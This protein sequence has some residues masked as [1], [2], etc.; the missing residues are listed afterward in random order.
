ML[1]GRNCLPTSKDEQVAAAKKAAAAPLVTSLGLRSKEIG[2]QELK[3]GDKEGKTALPNAK[4]TPKPVEEDDDNNIF[5]DVGTDYDPLAGLAEDDGSET[6]SLSSD[7]DKDS[8]KQAFSAMPP[9]LRPKP[10]Y[11][12]EKEEE[13]EEERSS[14]VS[15]EELEKQKKRKTVLEGFVRDAMDLDMGFGGTSEIGEVDDEEFVEGGKSKK[16]KRGERK[17]EI[18]M[19]QH[20]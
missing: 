5:D 1:R 9:L 10:N 8:V 16:R 20:W 15:T 18:K 6:D 13:E 12:N 14:A 17:R 11:F 3:K 19:M 2:Q 4:P 7:D